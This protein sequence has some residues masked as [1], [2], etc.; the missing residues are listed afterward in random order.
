MGRSIALVQPRGGIGKSTAVAQ[1]AASLAATRPDL[2]VVVIDASVHGDASTLL[3]GGL[4]EPKNSP[5]A[6]SHGEELCAA[7]VAAGKSTAAL[8]T[9]FAGGAAAAAPTTTRATGWGRLLSSSGGGNNAVTAPAVAM[10][11][12]TILSTY[13]VRVRDAYPAGDA[14]ENLYIVVGG[15]TLTG[16]TNEQ[17]VRAS[18]TIGSAFAAAPPN[19]VYLLDTDAEL[20]ER[21]ASACA[22]A[23]AGGLALLS[24]ANWSDFLRSLTDPVNGITIALSPPFPPKKIE[25]VIFTR[26][27]K[28]RN[29]QATVAGAPVSPFKPVNNAAA[30]IEQIV[31][32]VHD[33]AQTGGPMQPYVEANTTL[34]QFSEDHVIVVPDLPENVINTSVLKGTPVAYMEA[35]GAVT[36]DALG[37]AQQ[38]LSFAAARLV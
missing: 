30:N 26:V 15:A 28:T 12:A 38:Q 36:A 11:H 7:Q 2:T 4:Q 32:Y 3:V 22:A 18:Q 23:A 24:S 17:A 8:M 35:G 14:P 5:S 20:C 27:A 1:L 10:T 37:A 33:R 6:R 34:R 29:E 16:I 19:V 21:P 13:A 31:N 9:A 25:R